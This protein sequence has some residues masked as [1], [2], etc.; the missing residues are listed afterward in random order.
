MIDRNSEDRQNNKD[1]NK[2]N[3]KSEWDFDKKVRIICWLYLIMAL[4]FFAALFIIVMR[5]VA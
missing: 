2:N 4:I 1:S 5:I 3:G